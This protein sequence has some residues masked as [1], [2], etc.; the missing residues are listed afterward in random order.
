VEGGGGK[1]VL[2]RGRDNSKYAPT[3]DLIDKKERSGT[4][5]EEGTHERK[6]SH[7]PVEKKAFLIDRKGRVIGSPRGEEGRVRNSFMQREKKGRVI[8]LSASWAAVRRKG[9]LGPKTCP[10]SKGGRGRKLGGGGTALSKGGKRKIRGKRKNPKNVKKGRVGGGVTWRG[11]SLRAS[12][13]K[14]VSGGG[15]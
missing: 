5:S 14:N 15:G 1:P 11:K 8:T 4:K 13:E 10:P 6:R 12:E 9:L 3:K 2:I 7:R